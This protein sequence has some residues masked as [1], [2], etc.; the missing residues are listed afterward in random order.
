MVEGIACA[1]AVTQRFLPDATAYLTWRCAGECDDVKGIQHAGGIL[2]Q[3]KQ[4]RS[5]CPWKGIQPPIRTPARKYSPL[6]AA[7]SCTRRRTFPGLGPPSGPWDDPS[8][9]WSTMPVSSRGPRRRRSWWCHTPLIDPQNLHP[10]ETGGV[11]RCGVRA[12]LDM[13]PHGIPRGS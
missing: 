1:P 13:G 3:A 7:S 12:R 8:R 10:C 6:S 5:C 9:E 4:W 2:E 11:I